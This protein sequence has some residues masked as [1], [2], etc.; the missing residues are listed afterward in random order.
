MVD[1]I[2]VIAVVDA[3]EPKQIAALVATVVAFDAPAY[4]AAVDCS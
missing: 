2:A 4:A 1:V 3:D